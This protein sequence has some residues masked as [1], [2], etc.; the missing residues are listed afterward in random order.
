MSLLVNLIDRTKGKQDVNR[1]VD[2]VAKDETLIAEL[3][4]L[5]LSIDEHKSMKASWVLRYVAEKNKTLVE[6]HLS[7][8]ISHLNQSTYSC[9]RS[10]LNIIDYYTISEELEDLTYDQCF[11]VLLDSKSSVANKATSMN[12][13]SKICLKYP[14]LS[15]ELILVIQDLLINATPGIKSKG[16]KVIALLHK[17]QNGS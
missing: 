10:L 7:K 11:K 15:N 12:I 16:N 14:E 4:D 5:S 6:P 9:Q 3:V 8:I 2:F 1:A 17:A 13:L